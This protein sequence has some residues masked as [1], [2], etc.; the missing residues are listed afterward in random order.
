MSWFVWW[1]NDV[2]GRSQV[3]ESKSQAKPFDISKRVVWEAYL[4][5]KA[6]KGAAGVDGQ[7]IEQYE[8]DTKEQPVQAVESALVGELLPA[9]GEGRGDTEGRGQRG[10]NPRG[11]YRR[12]PDRPD[13]SGHVP[14]AAGGAG[15]PSGLLWLSVRG[16]RRWMRW[17]CA[18]EL[19]EER[20]GY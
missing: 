17:G 18:G 11:A 10:P 4:R 9:A 20:L 5:V 16:G 2:L 12:R 1:S 14:G 19:L 15:V 8:Q 3:S 7:T 6:N 13:G